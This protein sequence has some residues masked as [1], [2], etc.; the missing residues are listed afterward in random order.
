[1]AEHHI[2]PALWTDLFQRNI[3]NLL[4]LIEPTRGLALRIAGAR[5]E[6]SETSA[7]EHHD[8]SAVLAIFLLGRFLL[9]GILEIRKVY[10]IFFRERATVR[11]LFV[12][13]TAS[14]E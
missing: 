5:H 1:M 4:C 2:A 10:C 11:I 3:R 6:L 7:L 8:A 14:K 12:V 9:F 13:G